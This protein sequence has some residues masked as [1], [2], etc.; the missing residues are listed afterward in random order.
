MDSR[1][2]AFKRGHKSLSFPIPASLV[3]L[4][5]VKLVPLPHSG[6][7]DYIIYHDWLT[8]TRREISAI[9]VPADLATENTKAGLLRVI[10]ID[11]EDLENLKEGEWEIHKLKAASAEAASAAEVQTY[12]VPTGS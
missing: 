3:D 8:T 1:R 7:G 4:P 6:N 2:S 12:M 9:Q 5:P 11:L 10:S